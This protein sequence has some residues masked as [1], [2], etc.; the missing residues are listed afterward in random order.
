LRLLVD[1][2]TGSSDSQ[3]VTLIASANTLSTPRGAILFIRAV[4][5]N[6]FPIVGTLI[7]DTLHIV[8]LGYVAEP[9]PEVV[10]SIVLSRTEISFVSSA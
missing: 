2:L 3:G 1:R 9:E 5:Y 4:F 6:D 7:E 8:Q 10:D